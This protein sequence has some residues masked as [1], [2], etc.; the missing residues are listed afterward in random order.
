MASKGEFHH[1]QPIRV[2]SAVGDDASGS[3]KGQ[4]GRVLGVN[5]T[6]DS[7][8]NGPMVNVQ[9]EGGAVVAVPQA[10]V[11]HSKR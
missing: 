11:Q 3:L 1:G 9:L 6:F 10:A 4:R 8:K 2:H 7:A 5:P